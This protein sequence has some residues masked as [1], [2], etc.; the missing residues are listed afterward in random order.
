MVF[1]QPDL[2]GAGPSDPL[3]QPQ[4]LRATNAGNVTL[5]A[6]S[7]QAG[8]RS[9]SASAA[10]PADVDYAGAARAGA[11]MARQDSGAAPRRGDSTG[12]RSDAAAASD[13]HPLV[14]DLARAM[15]PN[16]SDSDMA[17]AQA[18]L[19]MMVAGGHNS[20][21]L[22]ALGEGA[23]SGLDYYQKLRAFRA[24][25]AMNTFNAESEDRLRQ[26]QAQYYQSDAL[27]QGVQAF[28]ANYPFLLRSAN[29]SQQPVYT[30]FG[31][32]GRP[33]FVMPGGAIRAANA[34]SIPSPSPQ[35]PP[36][37]AP[38]GGGAPPPIPN[39]VSPPLANMPQS[40]IER[41]VMADLGRGPGVDNSPAA[42]DAKLTAL[43][44]ANR[45]P[46]QPAP[47]A[48]PQPAPPQPGP[49]PANRQPVNSED[50]NM[51]TKADAWRPSGYTQDAWEALQDASEI[52]G[53]GGD[54][55][56]EQVT[57]LES[58]NPYL[59]AIRKKAEAT[60][61]E[62]ARAPY[63]T[64]KTLD[65]DG[66]YYVEM[67]KADWLKRYQDN[68]N[69][70]LPSNTAPPPPSTN[71]AGPDAP[72]MPTLDNKTLSVK[73]VIP[74]APIGGGFPPMP[75][76]AS[77]PT[78][79]TKNMQKAA[80]DEQTKWTTNSEK[81]ASALSDLRTL[82]QMYK[83]TMSNEWAEGKAEL[84]ANLK[85]LS[86]TLSIPLTVS[87]DVFGDP[88]AIQ[89][90]IKSQMKQTFEI[91]GQFTNRITNMEMTS[92]QRALSN[93]D[94]QPA[95]NFKIVTGGIASLERG[96]SMQNGWAKA[97]AQGWRNPLAYEDAWFRANPLDAWQ[98]SV[99]R[100]A[101]NFAGMPLPPLNQMNGMATYVAKGRLWKFDPSSRTLSPY[102]GNYQELAIPG[103]PYE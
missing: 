9:P 14:L 103:V 10:T 16:S 52:Y 93:P 66:G 100:R 55:A 62:V 35:A 22:T 20:N 6:P 4:A 39:L 98:E 40:E 92:A 87:K 75:P 18:G 34:G 94:L 65:K 45:P 12:A 3:V 86:S 25:Q 63:Q 89:A 32:D 69:S 70:N 33:A 49:P 71:I 26:A 81:G 59:A 47:A 42:T 31:P 50:A 74:D 67:T 91:A 60:A 82:A 78:D 21:F 57:S 11:D 85:A 77:E 41:R 15:Q 13:M 76:N 95:A 36:P 72:P 68:A 80:G 17:L 64:V 99:T 37:A 58:Q 19:G 54:K 56:R 5:G 97:Q 30:A 53:P 73:S 1:G 7:E 23:Q 61:D 28:G 96:M 8:Y 90:A 84:A 38:P 79:F 43:A 24:Q 102:Q 101:G 48:S 27:R 2:L 46:D 83:L 88:A 29:K 44:N 51:Q